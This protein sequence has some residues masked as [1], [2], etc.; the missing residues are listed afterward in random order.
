MAG[1][2]ADGP[3]EDAP[4]V[5]CVEDAMPGRGGPDYRANYEAHM[6][7]VGTSAPT[8]LQHGRGRRYFGEEDHQVIQNNLDQG[9]EEWLRMRSGR[10]GAAPADY[11]KSSVFQPFDASAQA[12]R[13][14]TEAQ[15]KDSVREWIMDVHG[16][17]VS[18]EKRWEEASV[19]Q[20]G[21][22]WAISALTEQRRSLGREGHSAR[23]IAEKLAMMPPGELR[24]FGL[25]FG[26]R[27]ENEPP[28]AHRVKGTILESNPTLVSP[29]VNT[30]FGKQ[31]GGQRGPEGL[32]SA[33]RAPE[34]MQRRY[35]A[36]GQDHFEST[37]G[38]GPGSDA[39]ERHIGGRRHMGARDNLFGGGFVK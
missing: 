21:S 4:S 31:G 3:L 38:A 12:E 35:I 7:D 6:Q 1:P 25:R 37:G 2:A 27:N 11:P 39:F 19:Q 15:M 8:G 36:S 22:N 33:R 9:D 24:F 20:H 23:A 34:E 18:D 16:L 32:S 26:G 14:P 5:G 28:Q 30:A 10:R 29:G 17:V 13:P